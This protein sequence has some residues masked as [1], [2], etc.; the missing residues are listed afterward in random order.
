[1]E[2]RTPLLAAD[3]RRTVAA[4]DRRIAELEAENAALRNHID[5]LRS[6]RAPA[7]VDQEGNPQHA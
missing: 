1:M 5:E 4:R 6:G 7:H 3:V 2:L